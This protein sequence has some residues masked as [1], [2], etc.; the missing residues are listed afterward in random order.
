MRRSVP[1]D[2]SCARL[3]QVSCVSG[4]RFFR[5]P[6]DLLAITD[7]G[8]RGVEPTSPSTESIVGLRLDES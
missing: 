4:A 1:P 8:G 2:R 5:D 6:R 3:P 7:F